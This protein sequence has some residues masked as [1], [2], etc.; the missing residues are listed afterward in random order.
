MLARGVQ[1]VYERVPPD[2]VVGAPELWAGLALH[3]G[4]RAAP[5]A[6][7]RPAGDGPIWGTPSEQFAVWSA[8]GIE[9]V[10]LENAGL[11]HQE[12]LDELDAR[13]PGAVQL[14]ASWAGGMLVQ[15]AWD[16]ACRALVVPGG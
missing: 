5:S 3:T 6:R 13:C 4:R 16:D 1:A 8:A 11:V 7:F 10:V 15:L 12:A 14:Q 9:Y 2:A